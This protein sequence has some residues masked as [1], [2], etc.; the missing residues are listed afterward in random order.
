MKYVPSLPPPV[1]GVKA[2][3]EVKTLAVIKRVK[4]VRARTLPPH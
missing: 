4:P 3:L 2:G 1:T